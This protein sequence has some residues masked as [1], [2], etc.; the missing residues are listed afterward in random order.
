M[1]K[2]RVRTEILKN[3]P[4]AIIRYN[5]NMNRVIQFNQTIAL[6]TLT[7]EEKTKNGNKDYMSII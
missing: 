5:K 3:N 4:E 7:T 6:L 2:N 1:T